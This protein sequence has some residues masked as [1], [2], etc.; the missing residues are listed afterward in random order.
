MQS[1]TVHLLGISKTGSQNN[2]AR[3]R[4]HRKQMKMPQLSE[5]AEGE[6]ASM[7]ENGDNNHEMPQLKIE[8]DI[9][10][11][12]NP[13][14][15]IVTP[16]MPKEFLE[17]LGLLPDS[18]SKVSLDQ[19][20][21]QEIESKFTSL[22]LA[23]KTDKKTL[24]KRLEIQERTRDL[25]EENVDKELKGIRDK[26]DTL[27]HLCTD[28]QVRKE[29]SKIRQHLDTLQQTAARV[30]SRAEVYGAVQQEKRFSF[31]VDVMVTHVENLRRIHEKEH[32]ELEE[33]KKLL[34]DSRTLGSAGLDHAGGESM[35]P[36]RSSSVC[37]NNLPVRG[38]RR[39]VSEVALPRVLGG[40]GAPSLLQP[41]YSMDPR[42]KFQQ[43]VASASMKSAVANTLRRASLDRQST[44]S[45]PNSTNVS[46]EHS[47][48][49]SQDDTSKKDQKN[50]VAK[51]E[52][53][54]QKGYEQGLRANLGKD[55]TD[56]R[57]QQNHINH[58]LG[59]VMDTLDSQLTG[60]Q[61]TL[62][63]LLIERVKSKIPKVDLSWK[64]VRLT[65]AGFLFVMAI[66]VV[67]ISLLPA[68][69]QYRHM[70]EPPH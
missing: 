59:E 43:V 53:A 4:E 3:R 39:R 47:Q 10:Q 57:E 60:D 23:F 22:A 62:K 45:A 34:Q 69:M 19:L 20:S 58:S 35:F 38:A 61:K 9:V 56:L 51:E 42:T 12:T 5:L 21:E 63:E 30:S 11:P 48:D 68:S 29:L 55:L 6:N 31:A 13:F 27:N 18:H 64:K 7:E 36:R 40:T 44:S 8:G 14:D 70:D 15:E 67:L 17:K 66:I 1:T 28:P 33:A 49:R 2:L 24:E 32:A 37:L 46:R 54:F 50:K 52:E 16:S 25:A 41:S 26:L 65:L